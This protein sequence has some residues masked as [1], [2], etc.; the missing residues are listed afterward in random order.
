MNS[1]SDVKFFVDLDDTLV[2][3]AGGMRRIY[4]KYRP[5]V[6]HCNTKYE[7]DPA[8]RD[9]SWNICEQYQKD[10]GQLWY[11]LDLR[12]DAAELWM[13]VRQYE[14]EILTATGDPSFGAIDQKL[15]WVAENLCEKVKINFTRRAAEKAQ[16]AA[17]NHIL[18]DDKEKAIDPWI[19][20]GG[21]GILYTD[22]QDAI[23]Q[24]RELG[25]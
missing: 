9:E 21:I 19:D 17:P 20:A 13:Y 3:F 12:H 1:I 23:A 24:L 8:Y 14:V 4:K 7:L 25:L 2:D 18:I 16:Y 10:G 11:D 15:R 5:D 22:T 6:E